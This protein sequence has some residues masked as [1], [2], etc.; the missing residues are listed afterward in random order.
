MHYGK[1]PLSVSQIAGLED[2]SAKFLSQIIIPLKGAGLIQA[3]RG[4]RGGYE[5][6]RTPAE[7]SVLD[8]FRALEGDCF[9]TECLDDPAE[10]RRSQ[11]C[12]ARNIWHDLSGVIEKKLT[13]IT[14]GH[15]AEQARD[16]EQRQS[17]VYMI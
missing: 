14:F 2:I 7:I 11:S 1:R 6:T 12:V 17:P 10:C 3:T 5:L 15:L 13:A 8:V 9:L 16:L 4:A